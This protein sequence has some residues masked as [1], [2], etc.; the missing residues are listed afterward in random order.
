MINFHKLNEKRLR[1]LSSLSKNE[2]KVYLALCLCQED[3]YT[4]RTNEVRLSTIVNKSGVSDRS[5][6][7]RALEGLKK[8][9]AIKELTCVIHNT[10]GW[11][12]YLLRLHDDEEK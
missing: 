2:M 8:K 4:N 5:N 3:V 9:R 11:H 6:T 12:K 7:Y 10:A 1:K